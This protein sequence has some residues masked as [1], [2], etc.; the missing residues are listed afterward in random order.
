MSPCVSAFLDAFFPN[1]MATLVGAGAGVPAGLWVNRRVIEH[2]ADNERTKRRARLRQHL[3]WL[4]DAGSQ[5]LVLIREA[6]DA[7]KGGRW[8]SGLSLDLSAWDTLRQSVVP[9][10][11]SLDN[12]DLGRGSPGS[13]RN[14]PCSPRTPNGTSLLRPGQTPPGKSGCVRSRYSGTTCDG[15][16]SGSSRPWRRS[17]QPSSRS[18][19]ASRRNSGAGHGE[20]EAAQRQGE[21]PGRRAGSGRPTARDARGSEP[22]GGVS[23]VAG[24]Y[25]GPATRPSAEFAGP[26]SGAVSPHRPAVA[27]RSAYRR[28]VHSTTITP[29]ARGG[30][31]FAP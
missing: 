17:R 21:Q 12:L 13:T 30:F 26:C 28:L 22:A 7:M 4:L 2:Q 6:A 11:D 29:V 3:E 16:R 10:L 19:G 24:S 23:T 31:G 1:L 14:S 25:R 18:G 9:D 8:V 5:N 15:A 20:R 27:S